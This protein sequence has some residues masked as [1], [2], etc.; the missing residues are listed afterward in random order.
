MRFPM[1]NTETPNAPALK[2]TRNRAR[3]NYKPERDLFR[4]SQEDRYLWMRLRQAKKKP[5]KKK[6]GTT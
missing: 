6:S 2:P 3:P 1:R 5:A 4:G